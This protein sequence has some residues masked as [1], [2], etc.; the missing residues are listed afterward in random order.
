MAFYDVISDTIYELGGDQTDDDDVMD[1]IVEFYCE[2]NH[3]DDAA[4][5]ELLARFRAEEAKLVK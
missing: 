1:A 4:L 2:R 3:F 5:L